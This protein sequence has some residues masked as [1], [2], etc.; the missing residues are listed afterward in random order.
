M[1]NVPESRNTVIRF[2]RYILFLVKV[3]DLQETAYLTS[4]GICRFGRFLLAF[5]NVALVK[6]QILRGPRV[7]NVLRDE[8]IIVKSLL[9][10]TFLVSFPKERIARAALVGRG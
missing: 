3:N 8:W 10:D 1:V 9:G 7:P 5:A 2:L 6:T 4:D